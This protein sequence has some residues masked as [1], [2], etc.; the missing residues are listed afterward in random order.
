MTADVHMT[1]L[2]HVFFLPWVGKHYGRSRL[3][4]LLILGESHY[5]E[6]VPTPDWTIDLTREYAEGRWNHRFWTN[7]GQAITGLRH[8]EFDRSE[9][10]NSIAFYNYVQEIAAAGPRQAPTA[11]MFAGSEGAFFEV[12]SALKPTH[13]LAL[14]YRLWE[15]MPSFESDCAPVFADGRSSQC[16]YYASLDHAHRAIAIAIQHPSWGFSALQWHPLFQK[17]LSIVAE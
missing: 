3:G 4:R 2:P 8:W 1:K 16:G 14:G 11:E 12:I 9:F 17:F 15:Q 7:I 13:V 5:G 10:W 6:D